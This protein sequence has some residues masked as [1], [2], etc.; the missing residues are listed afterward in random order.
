[1]GSNEEIENSSGYRVCEKIYPAGF[2]HNRKN[3]FYLEPNLKAQIDILIKNIK[4]DWDFTIIVTGRG[5][6]RVGKSVLA[7]QIAAYWVAEVNRIYNK[8]IPF[9]T[10]NFVFDGR[11]LIE[12][13]NELGQKHPYSPLI[14][15]E[16]G[17]DLAG[18]KMINTMTQDVL[19]FYRE[20]GQYNLL[21]VLV[22][23]DF[24]DLPKAL[25]LTRSIFLLDVD[26]KPDS[27]GIFQRGYFNFYSRP[28]KKNLYLKGKREQDYSAWYYDFH[29][30]FLN[31]YPI[32]EEDY[33]A[34]KV[35][36]LKHREKRRTNVII[37]QRDAAWF[38][39]TQ[40]FG[41]SQEELASR[42]ANWTGKYITQQN[43][44]DSIQRFMPKE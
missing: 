39:L 6:V 2:S 44:S 18:T 1:M 8:K 12:Q 24:F 35:K 43:I 36:A 40:E 4:N 41:M 10:D 17:A 26:Y 16:A 38:M 42:T 5:E 34:S 37:D 28:N 3:G 7:M 13:G 21:N 23:P 29:G 19:D 15:D 33:R 30:R 31:F 9:N 11:K 22:L 32:N 27:E 14:Y 20:C 25:A